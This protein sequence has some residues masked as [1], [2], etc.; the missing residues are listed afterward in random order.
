MAPHMYA[1]ILAGK[2][3][4]LANPRSVVENCAKDTTIDKPVRRDHVRIR[5]S[6][7]LPVRI[8]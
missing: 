1:S 3:Y 4:D 8:I 7:V 6:L 5:S 2:N